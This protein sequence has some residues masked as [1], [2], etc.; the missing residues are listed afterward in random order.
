MAGSANVSGS[1]TRRGLLKKIL[2]AEIKIAALLDRDFRCSE[3]VAELVSVGKSRV[4]NF[5]IL[6]AKEIENYLLA[7]H[8]I[9]KAAQQKLKERKSGGEVTIEKICELIQEIALE[10]NTDVLS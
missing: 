4:Q 3:K 6:G 2:K 9:A 8:A 1:K 7:P 5:H 10:Q